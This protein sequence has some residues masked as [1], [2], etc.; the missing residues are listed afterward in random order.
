MFNLKLILGIISSLLAIACFVPYIKDIFKRKTTP[1]SYSWLI[2]SLLQAIASIAILHENG[3]FGA[4]CFIVSSALC[5]FVFFLSLKFGTKNITSF[6]TFCLIGAVIAIFIWIFMK[7][8]FYS[9]IL[10]T[11][12]DLVGFIPTYRKAYTEP[13]TETL[14]TY[15]LS[16]AADGF[17]L[18]ALSAY[19]L[20][21]VLYP[22][23]L[24]LTNF[25]LAI[26]LI[27]KR[28]QI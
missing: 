23:S 24:V 15:F 8:P 22:A 4:L 17:S 20:T 5:I 6:D 21:T 12:I 11:L 7:D 28:R 18:L 16:S 9:V 25:L 10:I 13:K 1:H 14:S 19:S 3:G 2:W 26:V 27:Y